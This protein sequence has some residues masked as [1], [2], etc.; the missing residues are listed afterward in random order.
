[1]KLNAYIIKD[2]TESLTLGGRIQSDAVECRIS[3]PG[4]Y[5]NRIK[6][7]NDTIYIADPQELL[8]DKV[9]VRGMCFL[10]TATPDETLLSQPADFLYPYAPVEKAQLLNILLDTFEKFN[11]WEITLHDCLNTQSPLQDIGDCSLLFFK[12]PVSVSTN[13]FQFLCYYELP[14]PKNLRLF[15]ESDRNS[16]LSDE[17][18]NELLLHPDFSKTWDSERPDYFSSIDQ[19]TRCI[20]CNIKL[21]GENKARL[22]MSEFDNPLRDSALAIIYIFSKFAAKIL[23]GDNHLYL[24][25]H[26]A[27]FDKNI[28]A[29]IHEEPYDKQQLEKILPIYGWHIDDTYYCLKILSP[30]DQQVGSITNACQRL[31]KLVKGSCALA[32]DGAILFLIN[33]TFIQKSKEDINAQIVVHLREFLLKA[34]ISTE[35]QSLT[36]LPQYYKQADIALRLGSK[37]EGMRWTHPFEQYALRYVADECTKVLQPE[38]LCIQGLRKLM[39]YDREKNRNYTDTLRVYLENNMNVAVTIRK[40]YMQRATFLYQLKKIEEISGLNLKDYNT[41]LYLMLSYLLLDKE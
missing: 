24:N 3:R 29:L 37:Y 28:M 36:S 11:N 40:I 33:L 22:V 34:G 8:I 4:F 26:P 35:F 20:Y 7:Q 25:N 9:D 6:L 19:M 1:M 17:E 32:D 5:T 13:S 41:R 31:E 12:N 16:F 39:E 14:K 2:F 15:N 18:V 21:G 38:T 23:A 30:A 27:Y 10:L